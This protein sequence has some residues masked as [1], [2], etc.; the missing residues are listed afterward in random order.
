MAV[1]S[2]HCIEISQNI[3]AR[4]DKSVA[5]VTNNKRLY[6]TFCTVEANYRQ[7]RS[8]ARPFCDSRATCSSGCYVD[9]IIVISVLFRIRLYQI[10][11]KLGHPLRSDDVMY[12]F[13]MAV[14]QYYFEFR[15]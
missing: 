4:S 12:N 3:T 7:I 11:S 9:H 6:S 14:A 15:I 10:S 8:I 13:K 5:Y 1:R 2:S